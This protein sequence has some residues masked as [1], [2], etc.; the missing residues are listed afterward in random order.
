MIEARTATGM[1]PG[2]GIGDG[3]ALHFVGTELAEVVGSRAGARAVHVSSG[4]QGVV[5]RELQTR[6]LGGTPAVVEPDE[7]GA[8]ASRKT[9]R[10]ARRKHQP[11]TDDS[12][13]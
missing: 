12:H 9:R 7:S 6:Y 1:P 13:D 5:E 11:R 4:E 3:A 2:Y 10:R 8:A